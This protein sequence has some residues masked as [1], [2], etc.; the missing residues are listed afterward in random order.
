MRMSKFYKG[1]R[2]IVK[3]NPTWGGGKSFDC[4]D[5]LG[6]ANPGT[7]LI[8]VDPD[9]DMW[10]DIQAKPVSGKFDCTNWF[11]ISED[12][13][14][15]AEDDVRVGDRIRV[16]DHE[17]DVTFE[18]TVIHIASGYTP[19]IGVYLGKN[20]DDVVYAGS[21]TAPERYTFTVLK[22]PVK[23]PD[24]EGFIRITGGEYKGERMLVWETDEETFIVR[25]GNGGVL[26]E[27]TSNKYDPEF[28]FEYVEG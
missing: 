6:D 26:T 20:K 12:S 16:E 3:D 2:V 19:N 27:Q 22:R 11:Y 15:S 8:V 7:M 9:T 4:V 28:D 24:H 18:G 23:W 17:R 5:P 25:R 1:Q 10:G 14:A 13:V 21:L